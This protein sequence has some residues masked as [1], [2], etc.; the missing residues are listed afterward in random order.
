MLSR[1]RIYILIIILLVALN[2][3]CYEY[4]SNQNI[5]ASQTLLYRGLFTLFFCLIIGIIKKERIFPT[6]IKQQSIR[7]VTTGGSLLLILMSYPFLSAGTVSL[8]Q[9][10]D[11]PFLIFISIISKRNKKLYQVLL[12]IVTV[13]AILFLTVNPQLI[14]EDI[15]GFLLVFASV[16]M[17]AVGY[18]TVHKGSNE[19]TVPSLINVSAVSSVFFGLITSFVFPGNFIFP[20]FDFM[21]IA[22][23]A[24]INVILFYLT[25]QLYKSYDPERALLPFV[26]AIISTS[27]LEMLIENKLYS[28]QDIF[29]TIGLT[30]LISIICLGGQR[31]ATYNIKNNSRKPHIKKPCN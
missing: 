12:S 17:T 22:L 15:N 26:W 27:I 19:E 10:L 14:D 28:K 16:L 18:F 13:I 9:R 25:V 8:L 24:I 21:I 29:I 30:V 31:R 5:K 4:L 3:N 6:N 7:F 20:V 11:I 1:N 2:N 23:S